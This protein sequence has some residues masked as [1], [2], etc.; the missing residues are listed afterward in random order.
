MWGMKLRA[1]NTNTS[2]KKYSSFPQE[3]YILMEEDHSLKGTEMRGERSGYPG[4]GMVEKS[5]LEPGEE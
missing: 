2:R 3:T 5:G 4:R 1:D